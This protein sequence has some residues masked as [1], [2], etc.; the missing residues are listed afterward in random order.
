MM[1]AVFNQIIGSVA[2]AAWAGMILS[3]DLS[4]YT[5][6]SPEIAAP[7]STSVMSEY[8]KYLPLGEWGGNGAG[9][10][11]TKNE[12]SAIFNTG[13]AEIAE[14]PKLNKKGEFN[15]TGRYR[16]EGPGANL[17]HPSQPGLA[18]SP[19]SDGDQ[20]AHFHGKVTGTRMSLTVTLPG[21]G[22]SGGTFTLELGKPAQIIKPM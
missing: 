22:G 6:D 8:Q 10:T 13:R 5:E 3:T 7:V 11:V 1:T 14:R 9:I 21:S 12:V 20:E 2:L 15:V 16:R 18:V 19:D 17:I 4:A